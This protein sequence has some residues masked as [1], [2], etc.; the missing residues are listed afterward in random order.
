MAQVA[1]QHPSDYKTRW[2]TLAVF[3]GSAV[4]GIAGAFVGG[5]LGS[6]TELLATF[7]DNPPR[8]VNF[9]G[10]RVTPE[11]AQKRL[12]SICG[13]WVAF[14][15]AVSNWIAGRVRGKAP[16]RLIQVHALSGEPSKAV[17]V[18]LAWADTMVGFLL[19]MVQQFALIAV[20]VGALQLRAAQAN[21]VVF[22]AAVTGVVGLILGGMGGW[23]T[24]RMELRYQEKGS[25]GILG[26]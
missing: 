24:A 26:L 1:S 12:V 6:N 8:Q 22:G 3:V 23:L 9:F 17:P 18:N 4:G 25:N 7:G 21:P 15:G 16:G 2:L 10:A 13:L 14:V 5:A 19:G 11:R 20:A